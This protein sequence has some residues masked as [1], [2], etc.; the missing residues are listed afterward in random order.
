[1][2]KKKSKAIFW[3]YSVLAVIFLVLFSFSLGAQNYWFMAITAIV[4][5]TI[6]GAG[7][8]TK[9]KYRENDWF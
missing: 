4:L 3:I 5:I 6:F 9:K 7:F 8:T 2:Q 1:M